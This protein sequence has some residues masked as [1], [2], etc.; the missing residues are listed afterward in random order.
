MN[1]ITYKLNLNGSSA[2][3]YY[4][5]VASFT[6]EVLERAERT[7]TPIAKKYRIFLIGYELEDPRSIEEYSYELLNLGIL[8]RA[9]GSTALA[10][11]V[12]PFH[13]MAR[14]GEWRKTHPRWKPLIDAIRGMIL[15][16]FLVPQPIHRTEYAPRTLSDLGRLISWLEATGDFREDAFRYIRWLGFL[17]T[18]PVDYFDSLMKNVLE[19]ADWFE[20]E[21]ELQMGVY[22]PYV[23][24]FISS[25]SSHYRWREDRFSC[26]RSRVEYHMNMVG[27][28]I[29]NRA[30]RKEFASCDSRTVLLPGCMRKRSEED[31]EGIKT[32][33]GIQCTGCESACHVNQL[34]E[35]GRRNNFDVMVIPH[36][37]DLGLW[38]AKPGESTTAVVGVAC[39]P[40]L[41]QG[42]WELKRNNI[43]AQCV[44]LD[45]CGCKKHWHEKGFPTKLDV[46][47]L[48]RIVAP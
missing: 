12:A 38:S 24:S 14:L 39:L 5:A 20:K 34:R 37:T 3:S 26:L 2:L 36:S 23:D 6:D 25:R 35:M 30:Y 15:S 46:R 41:V 16:Y 7:I 1:P 28:E 42:G 10:V 27:A 9:Y 48:K 11:N 21:S 47:E 33:K 43:P 13:F 29:M 8:W 31:C 40:V 22:T 44:L 19:F 17:G 4:P 32:K 18:K 45:E